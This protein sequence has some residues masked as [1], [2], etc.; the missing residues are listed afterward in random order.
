MSFLNR[1]LNHP[2][3]IVFF[4]TLLT[5]CAVPFSLK[6]HDVLRG[7]GFDA[8][9]AEY[10]LAQKEIATHFGGHPCDLYVLVD[11]PKDFDSEDPNF[12]IKVNEVFS[13]F[14]KS[15][16]VVSYL[17]YGN[18][19]DGRFLSKDSRY[20]LI[21]FGFN[22][23]EF[24][25][26][27]QLKTLKAQIKPSDLK[28][29]WIGVPDFY[30]ALSEQSEKDALHGELIALPFLIIVLLLM[31]RTLSGIVLPLAMAGTSILITLAV[32]FGLS[33]FMHLSIFVLNIAS[34]LGIGLAVDYSLLMISR[35]REE[36]SKNGNNVELASSQTLTHAGHAVL[37]SAFT[38]FIGLG[39]LFFFGLM[40]QTSMAIG[41]ILVISVALLCSLTLLPAILKILGTRVNQLSV[42]PRL[43]Q[44]NEP[45]AISFWERL[46]AKA[47]ARPFFS[48]LILVGFFM[49]AASPL[50]HLRMGTSNIEILPSEHPLRVDTELM[51]SEFQETPRGGEMTLFFYLGNQSTNETA[52][53]K[54]EIENFKNTLSS[55]AHVKKIN[56][57]FKQETNANFAK[58]DLLTDFHY[59]DPAAQTFLASLRAESFHHSKM[60]VTGEE[61]RLH[62][63]VEALYSH[64]PKALLFVIVL[65]Y[66]ILLFAFRSYLL[67]IKAILLTTLSLS[68]SYGALVLIFQDGTL[69]SLLGVTG[70]G[71]VEAVLP[72]LLFSILF[73]LSMD[74][75]VFLISRIREAW[76]ATGDNE[77]SILLGI[78]S[79]TKLVT[80]AALGMIMVALGFTF[81]KV[82]PVKA[83]GL[84]M[85]LAVGVDATLIRGLL[86]P[87]TMKLLGK[88][89]WWG[90]FQGK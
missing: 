12:F 19:F 22:Q 60:L 46:G 29:H 79:S 75:E 90:P 54:I 86:L 43:F 20:A 57:S 85:I 73:G 47:M 87:V 78:R 3:H 88:W 39:S 41:G 7:G 56:L 84:G 72:I 2:W 14:L 37:A 53:S 36:L 21:A 50:L 61:A 69:S 80:F 44:T 4:W 70:Q 1:L 38:V 74:Y 17:H 31:F 42:L 63:F 59:G 71:Y 10:Y 35:F 83:I 49:L 11:L 24:E 65:T 23:D 89:N 34:L 67:P 52:L 32:L 9:N 18:T 68:C 51:T 33:H 45:S 30:L 77:K 27:A 64:F 28:L 58:I 26:Q 66:F 81:A 55:N 8:P 15:T 40:I 82:L 25:I 76:L 48:L 5:L 62:D 16:N 6:L 13:D